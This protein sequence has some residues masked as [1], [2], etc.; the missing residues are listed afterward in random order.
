MIGR[1]TSLKVS[2]PKFQAFEA[3][4]RAKA[5]E[6][7]TMVSYRLT[8]SARVRFV[9]EH[10]TVGRMVKGKCR[11]RTRFND[12]GR[13]CRIFVHEKPTFSRRGRRGASH[14]RFFG[15]LGPEA[16]EPGSTG[17]SPRPGGATRSVPFRVVH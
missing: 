9:V 8:A 7:G 12:Y 2:P 13:P 10:K 5:G 11:K 17:S 1:I 16:L 14:F 15:R 6:A 4:D 3:G